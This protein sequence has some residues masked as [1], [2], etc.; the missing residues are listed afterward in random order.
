M[1]PTDGPT[2]SQDEGSWSV[3][4]VLRYKDGRERNG[5]WVAPQT[6]REEEGLIELPG[7]LV[8]GR[9]RDGSEIVNLTVENRAK[10]GPFTVSQ[11]ADELSIERRAHQLARC[12]AVTPWRL[13]L[14][15][16]LQ[17]PAN[18]STVL[19]SH[20]PVRLRIIGNFGNRGEATALAPAD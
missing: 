10:P 20:C 13:G 5:L 12:A 18:R 14:A 15:V 4:C 19:A 16:K 6:L 8:N 3:G 2:A 17:R 7:S 11:M 1:S 9:E